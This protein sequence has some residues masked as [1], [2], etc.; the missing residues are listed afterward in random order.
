MP[1]AWEAVGDGISLTPTEVH[2]WRAFLDR[3][4]AHD[5][6][7]WGSLAEDERLRAGRIRDDRQRCRFATARATLRRLAARYLHGDPGQVQFCY[8]ERGK[9]FLAEAERGLVDGERSVDSTL[10]FNVSHARGVGLFAFA[11]RRRIGIDVESAERQVDAD[12]IAERF[13]SAQE[14]SALRS[15]HPAAARRRAF[16]R[17]W[18]RKE[19][20][21]K[22]TGEGIAGGAL[23]RFAV[24]VEPQLPACLEWVE[25]RPEEVPRWRLADLPFDDGDCFGAVCVEGHDWGMR[26]LSCD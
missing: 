10:S 3:T 15:L 20:Y 13:F 6:R 9:P 21:L 17:C 18:T 23:R 4:T 16:L 2:V 26:C 1:G 25:G 12:R 22:A 8:D 14:A 24:A 19:A 5:E 11:L 7:L